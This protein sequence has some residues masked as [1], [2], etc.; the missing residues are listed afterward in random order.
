LSA[1]IASQRKPPRLHLRPH[2]EEAVHADLDL[3]RE[4]AGDDGGRALVRDVQHLHA[5]RL[6]EELDADVLE[7]ARA[8]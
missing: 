2:A 6:V 8:R 1:V 7:R 4:H 5:G 3:V